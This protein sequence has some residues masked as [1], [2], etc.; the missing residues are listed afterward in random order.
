MPFEIRE[1][2]QCGERY[3]VVVTA[4][5]VRAAAGP[6]G[7]AAPVYVFLG[8]SRLPALNA[9]VL[10]DMQ[11]CPQRY[12]RVCGSSSHDEDS[13]RSAPPIEGTNGLAPPLNS[14]SMENTERTLIE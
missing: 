9:E 3:L 11:Q 5:G 7:T 10:L 2:A 4:G 13:Q 8:T 14:V 12:Q 6:L 1:H